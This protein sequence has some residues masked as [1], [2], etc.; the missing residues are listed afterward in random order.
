M[1]Y[2]L[3]NCNSLRE[4][5]PNFLPSLPKLL[6]FGLEVGPGRVHKC[7]LFLQKR[8]VEPIGAKDRNSHRK[9]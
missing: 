4:K 7:I 2:Q 9:T 6:K 1:S 3:Q 8:V 5:N